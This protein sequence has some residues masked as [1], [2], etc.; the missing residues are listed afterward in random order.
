LRILQ[1]AQS[2]DPDTLYRASTAQTFSPTHH[3]LAFAV[4]PASEIGPGFSPDIQHHQ[5]SGL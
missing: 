3:A 5:K 1:A 2:K 4:A